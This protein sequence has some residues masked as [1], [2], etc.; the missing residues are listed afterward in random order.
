[1][2]NTRSTPN[3]THGPPWRWR[4]TGSCYPS[5]CYPSPPQ[6][7]RA[8]SQYTHR[9]WRVCGGW[10]CP[11][12]AAAHWPAHSG[13]LQPAQ[14]RQARA[15]PPS[16]RRKQKCGGEDHLS[17]LAR[18]HCGWNRAGGHPAA[19]HV[20][21]AWLPPP[22]PPPASHCRASKA[23]QMVGRRWCHAIA[24]GPCHPT[25]S[26]SSATQ[27]DSEREGRETP[28]PKRQPGLCSPHS[29]GGAK[30]HDR[31]GPPSSKRRQRRGGE[32]WR[33]QVSKDRRCG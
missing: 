2:W 12:V 13:V 29:T 20:Q 9:T 5:S 23:S 33:L 7:S 22:L 6:P 8:P 21:I 25:S 14:R 16:C 31:A 32:P 10:Q 1:M 17:L 19:Q 3:L 18:S 30:H 28:V 4:G 11:A 27:Q 15:S 26:S 24:L